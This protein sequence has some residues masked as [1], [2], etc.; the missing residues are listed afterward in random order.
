MRPD[1][2]VKPRLADQ[3]TPTTT[4]GTAHRAQ[5][6]ATRPRAGSVTSAAFGTDR[7]TVFCEHNLLCCPWSPWRLLSSAS[8]GWLPAVRPQ[9]SLLP[10]LQVLVDAP[11]HPADVVL[12]RQLDVFAGHGG[13][14]NG[15]EDHG[16]WAPHQVDRASAGREEIEQHDACHRSRN[17]C[18]ARTTVDAHVKPL[19]SSSSLDDLR[20]GINREGHMLT[21]ASIGTQASAVADAAAGAFRFI[22]R[23]EVEDESMGPPWDCGRCCRLCT[24]E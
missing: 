14:A 5:G 18:T 21:A 24:S 1:R 7:R 2:P 9:R 16:P 3:T 8:T 17:V 19:D 10:G 13:V 4:P 11:E 20:T 12:L 23:R 22:P 6:P 15:R